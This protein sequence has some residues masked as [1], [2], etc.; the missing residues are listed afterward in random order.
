[1]STNNDD[2]YPIDWEIFPMDQAT[3]DTVSNQLQFSPRHKQIVER[4]LHGR[5]RK[6]IVIDLNSSKG[7]IDEHFKRI[8]RNNG[9]SGMDELI[10][11]IFRTTNALD[12]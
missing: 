12:T 1:M 2:H 11:L 9:I 8:Y 4:V 5:K 7:T 6:Q 3:W 10:L